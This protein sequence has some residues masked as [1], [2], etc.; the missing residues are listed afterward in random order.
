MPAELFQNV[1]N[2]FS[3][4]TEIAFFIPREVG[5][6]ELILYDM[7]GTQI[8]N[9]PISERGEGSV[10]LSGFGLQP[11]IYLYA[12]VADGTWIDTKKMLLR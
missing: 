5:T 10:R 2:P 1:P 4:E 6:A 7:Q 11:G 12:L 3:G 9:I 8:R